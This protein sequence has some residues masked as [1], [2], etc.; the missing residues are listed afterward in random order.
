MTSRESATERYQT[1]VTKNLDSL[2]RYTN[3]NNQILESI[4]NNIG[5]VMK[6]VGVV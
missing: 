4:R 5:E 6:A 2:A 1:G 3:D